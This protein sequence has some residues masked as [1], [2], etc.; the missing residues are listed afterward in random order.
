MIRM[1]PVT[2]IAVAVGIGIGF[3]IVY[4]WELFY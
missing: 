4:I 1:K 2:I 3:G